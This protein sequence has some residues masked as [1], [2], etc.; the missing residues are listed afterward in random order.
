MA[1]GKQFDEENGY[2]NSR[3]I[4]FYMQQVAKDAGV[5]EE[6]LAKQILAEEETDDADGFVEDTLKDQEALQSL[7]LW[8]RFKTAVK[9]PFTS[10]SDWS[11][12]HDPQWKSAMVQ[13]MFGDVA[14]MNSYYQ[15]QK[16]I[17]E[18][19]K[20]REFQAEQAR[21][22][23]EAQQEYN[24]VWKQIEEAKAKKEQIAVDRK[25]ALEILNKGEGATSIEKLEL[26]DL[27][28]KYDNDALGIK[29]LQN[30]AGAQSTAD[31]NYQEYM[32]TMPRG[33]AKDAAWD[34]WLENGKALYANDPV[35]LLEIQKA[36][37]S[38][39]KTVE[40]EQREY[41]KGQ[42][43]KAKEEE[44]ADA[45]EKE[46]RRKEIRDKIASLKKQKD[47]AKLQREKLRIQS[48]IDKLNAELSGI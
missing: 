36:Y 40:E 43:R 31:L 46:K 47:A 21:L 4:A 10:M 26:E 7:G 37:N 33:E 5:T 2:E 20:N 34:A 32:G 42:A 29:D 25:R 48:E 16:Q 6:E 28:N 35:K 11:D 38:R 17:E 22:N 45:K 3:E 18:A 8:D 9:K 39:G 23:R 41:G 19:Q 15:Q 1:V 12:S 14:P 27:L 30:R 13:A 24:T 44:K